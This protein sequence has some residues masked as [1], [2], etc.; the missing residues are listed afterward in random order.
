[1]LWDKSAGLI[2][3]FPLLN[4]NIGLQRNSPEN[5]FPRTDSTVEHFDF[6]VNVLENNHL[7]KNQ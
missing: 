6:F 2:R 5:E 3:G 1:M 7:F 4:Q